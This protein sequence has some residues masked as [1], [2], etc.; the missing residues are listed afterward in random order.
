MSARLTLE[1]LLAG[2][3]ATVV[4]AA[5]DTYG[6]LFGRRIT[7]SRLAEIVDHVGID[8]C[9]C[10]L[11]W[12]ITQDADLLVTGRLAYTGLHTGLGDLVLL[13]DLTTLRP[14]AWR[15]GVALVFAEARTAPGGPLVDVAP[16]TILHRQVERLRGL[17]YQ[18]SVGTELE[19]YLYDDPPAELAARDYRDPTPTTRSPADYS[20]F[21]GNRFEPFFQQLRGCLEGSGVATEA[22]Q[23]EFGLGQWEL[24][25]RHTDPLEM[26]DRHALYKLAVRELAAE[27]SMTATFMA[28]PFET[29]MGSSCHIHLSLRDLDAR[30]VFGEGGVDDLSDSDALRGAV[31]GVLAHLRELTAWYAPTVN[32][33]RRIRSQDAAGWGRTWGLDNRT[34]SVR[35]L[36]HDAASRRL[37][38]RVPGADV[39]PYLVLAA[40]LASVA[41]GIERGVEPGPRTDGDA[42]AGRSRE[43]T[44]STLGE[45]AGLLAS[46]DF[47]R[48]AFGNEVIDHHV[49]LFGHE[50]ERFCAT[51][52]EW[53]RRRYLELI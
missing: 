3:F 34:C 42:Y 49:Q 13:P 32:S 41:D 7:P 31:G 16:R 25:V 48:A 50:W 12:D 28:R 37:E 18:A 6:R 26:A 19:F 38:L 21:E 5:P 30:P 43:E 15:Q 24:T 11:G 36:G 23:P 39:N 10:V 40:V 45:A 27:H 9:A 2:D 1:D 53:E 47:A 4:V 8:V 33:Y 44:P 14:L 29:D 20:I 46:S 22:V 52:T 51:V 17:G 35:V